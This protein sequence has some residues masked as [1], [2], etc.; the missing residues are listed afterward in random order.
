MKIKQFLKEKHETLLANYFKTYFLISCLL[1][2]LLGGLL[3]FYGGG[4][5][6]DLFINN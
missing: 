2:S 4:F 5:L 6:M 1:F 3:G